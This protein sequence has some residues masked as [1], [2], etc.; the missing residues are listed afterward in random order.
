MSVIVKARF[1]SATGGCIKLWVLY[2]TKGYSPLDMACLSTPTQESTFFSCKVPTVVKSC[3]E[4][5]RG[6]EGKDRSKGKLDGR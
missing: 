3:D 2:V 4:N 1:H 6:R 5:L